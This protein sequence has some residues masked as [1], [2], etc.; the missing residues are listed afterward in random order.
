MSGRD[1][2]A[3]PDVSV[4]IPTRDR[5]R[6]LVLALRSALRQREV[7]LEVVVVDDGSGDDTPEV[8]AGLRDA[9]VH[10]VRHPGPH[11]VS[12]ARNSGIAAARGR[13]I[14]FLDDD[15][16]AARVGVRR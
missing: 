6:L 7:D 11:G 15:D 4:V 14:A 3:A 13:W 9:R 8:V 5:S 10:L 1:G 2:M 16:L 12:A